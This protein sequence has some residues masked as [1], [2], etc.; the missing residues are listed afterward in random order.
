[1]KKTDPCK[2]WKE[3]LVQLSEQPTKL[4]KSE[5]DYILNRLIDHKCYFSDLDFQSESES[6]DDAS[7]VS[8]PNPSSSQEL[9]VGRYK[10]KLSLQR[11]ASLPNIS[12][13][14]VENLKKKERSKAKS[15]SKVLPLVD[16]NDNKHLTS[17]AS[18]ESSTN[19][20]ADNSSSDISMLQLSYIESQNLWTIVERRS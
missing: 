18:A 17:S 12:H 8:E 16:C 4:D 1:M 5:D 13:A 2:R 10:L 6:T 7:I 11:S 15:S 14:P 20:S 3:W 19:P 9:H